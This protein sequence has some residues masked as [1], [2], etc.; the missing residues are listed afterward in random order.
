MQLDILAKIRFYDRPTFFMTWS[1]NQFHWNDLI[2]AVAVH[3]GVQLTDAEIDAMS[4]VEK[5]NWL[6][7]N[8][9][10]V[11]RQINHVF[12]ALWGKVVVG[13]CIPSEK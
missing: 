2:K 12:K 4:R 7:R 3:F 1:A 9:V 11:A 6:K 10:T 5:E 8:P 13:G